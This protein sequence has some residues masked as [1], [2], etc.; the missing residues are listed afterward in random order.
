MIRPYAL[1]LFWIVA[2]IGSSATLYHTSTR[3][4]ALE[5]QLRKV[6]AAIEDEQKSIHVLRAEWVYLSHPSRIETETKKHLSLKTTEP[7]RVAALQSMDDFFPVQG[8]A[9]RPTRLAQTRAQEEPITAPPRRIPPRTERERILALINAG[10]IND[11]MTMERAPVAKNVKIETTSTARAFAGP[12]TDKIGILI[13][14]LG[15]RP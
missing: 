11:R 10:R 14:K 3:V 4:T 8:N 2:I 5:G 6:H 13:G 12:A 1:I 15:M 9:V 7:K